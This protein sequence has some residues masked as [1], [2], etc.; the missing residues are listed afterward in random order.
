[1]ERVTSQMQEIKRSRESAIVLGA[2]GVMGRMPAAARRAWNDAFVGNAVA[3]VTNVKG[4]TAP[5]TL[6]GTRVAGMG[7]W[8]PS[9]GPIGIGI[10][11]LSYAGQAVV[12]LVVD[13][14]LASTSAGLAGALDLELD[15]LVSAG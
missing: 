3:V 7:L 8:V 1:M 12:T 15:R 11:V 5:V 9:T 2:L 10:S 13:E 14:G 4:P 6:A